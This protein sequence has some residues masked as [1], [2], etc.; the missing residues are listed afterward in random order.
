MPVAAVV[1]IN[2]EVLNTYFKMN[3]LCG[4]RPSLFLSLTSPYL[5]IS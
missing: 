2:T 5:T 4:S 1:G 3:Q